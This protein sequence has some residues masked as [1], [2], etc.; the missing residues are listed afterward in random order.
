MTPTAG[1]EQLKEA[2]CSKGREG[3]EEPGDGSKTPSPE[4]QMDEVGSSVKNFW[5]KLSGE[6]IKPI[7]LLM[8]IPAHTAKAEMWMVPA[9][10]SKL[11]ISQRGQKPLAGRL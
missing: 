8:P 7:R 6:K 1:I 11:L 10:Q 5:V 3:K 9:A 2:V 4:I